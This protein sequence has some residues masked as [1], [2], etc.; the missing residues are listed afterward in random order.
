MAFEGH[1]LITT[2]E[3]LRTK[4]NDV[5]TAALKLHP[6]EYHEAIGEMHGWMVHVLKHYTDFDCAREEIFKVLKPIAH[7]HALTQAVDEVLQAIRQYKLQE[8]ALELVA[9]LGKCR[10][11]ACFDSTLNELKAVQRNGGFKVEGYP[12]ILQPLRISTLQRAI[13]TWR[14]FYTTSPDLARA[15]LRQITVEL[16]S[17]GH[18]VTDPEVLEIIGH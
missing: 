15:N 4:I 6:K 13:K 7:D 1:T 2:K 3:M 5:I 18:P 12:E 14:H 11:R 17:H 10:N 8:K 16:S 9:T